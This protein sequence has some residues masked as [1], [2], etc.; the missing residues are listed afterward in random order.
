LIKLL[1]S[2][3]NCLT[4]IYLTDLKDCV[5]VLIN[6]VFNQM[7]KLHCFKFLLVQT[8]ALNFRYLW[9]KN[10]EEINLSETL[11]SFKVVEAS[12]IISWL[13]LLLDTLDN[14]V[15]Y[16]ANLYLFSTTSIFSSTS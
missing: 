12:D 4:K 14:C 11:H 16:L 7:F 3:S 10:K 9:L 2:C 5:K 8:I 15:V 13:D 6:K 1:H